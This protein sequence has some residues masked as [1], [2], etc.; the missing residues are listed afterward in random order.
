MVRMIDTVRLD[1]LNRIYQYIR[2]M[3]KR[4]VESPYY[5][6][7]HLCLNIYKYRKILVDDRDWDYIFFLE[8]LKVKLTGMEELFREHSMTVSAPHKAKDIQICI[9]LIDRILAN[10]YVELIELRLDKEYGESE[11]TSIPIDNGLYKLVIDRPKAREGSEEYDKVK[12]IE[13]KM[14][15]HSAK[16]KQQD[17]NY[18]FKLIAKHLQTWWD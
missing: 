18:L 11:H 16:L 13:Q 12:K 1:N 2:D 14:F 9:T 3:W 15:F 10:N 5:T 6:V 7:K 4:L 8:L 17:I